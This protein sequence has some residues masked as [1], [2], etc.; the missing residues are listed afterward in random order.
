[1]DV[2]H[3]LLAFYL[4]I[5]FVGSGPTGASLGRCGFCGRLG[6]SCTRQSNAGH[7]RMATGDAVARG[8]AARSDLKRSFTVIRD[9]IFEVN[10][11][12]VYIYIYFIHNEYTS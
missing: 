6:C 1:M 4:L 3:R 10:S 5:F 9:E 12:C 7:A 2:G 11:V 8:G